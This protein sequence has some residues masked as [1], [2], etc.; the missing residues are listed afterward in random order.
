MIALQEFVNTCHK[1]LINGNK[2][3]VPRRYLKDTRSLNEETWVMHNIGFCPWGINLDPEVR[4]FGEDLNDPDK[5]D[6]RYNLW[7]KIIVPIYDEFG[8][9]ISISTKKP[10]VEK[11]PW[12]NIPFLKSHSLF[13]INKARKEMFVKNKVYVVEGYADALTLYQHGLKNVVAIMGTAFTLRKIAMV[14]R[15]CNNVCFCF[16]VDENKSG[17]NASDTSIV[18]LN[19]YCFC[20]NISV[21]DSIPIG[22]DPDS[23]VGKY[24]LESYLDHERILSGKDIKEICQRVNNKDKEDYYAK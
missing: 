22:E 1:R 17:Q 18:M 24:G 4:F 9:L 19:K 5:R 11:S 16:D 10:S 21:I 12:W 14:A 15:Y 6:W 13:L 7:G 2:V 23:Y 8:D 20:D 3:D